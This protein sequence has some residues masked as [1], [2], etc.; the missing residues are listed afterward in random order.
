MRIL[1]EKE[2]A[3][4]MIHSALCNGGLSEL[5]M[6][7]VKLNVGQT[8]YKEAKEQ[9][10]SDGKEDIC[11]EDVWV[12]ILRSGKAL[13]FLDYEGDEEQSFTLEKAI[14]EMGKEDAS[15]IILTYKEEQDD[16][17]T[18]VELLQYCLYGEVI[19]G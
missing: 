1:L 17:Y 7:G 15:E 19:Y 9:L 4:S 8:D 6:C 10:L 12:Q 2:E 5:R 16:A 3:L 13:E 14:E 18:A 11:R